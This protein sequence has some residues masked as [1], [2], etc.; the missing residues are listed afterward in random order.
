[1]SKLIASPRFSHRRKGKDYTYLYGKDPSEGSL[2]PFIHN[3]FRK[4]VAE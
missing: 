2:I 1:M 3:A 4:D